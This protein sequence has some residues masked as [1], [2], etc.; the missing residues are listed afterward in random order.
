MN[1]VCGRGDTEQGGAQVERHAVDGRGVCAAAE[2]VQL[3]ASGDGED[4][5]DGACF[6]GCCQQGTVTVESNA[7][8]W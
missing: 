7:G 3:L 4:A 8:Q 6:G 2:L 1:G 5:D